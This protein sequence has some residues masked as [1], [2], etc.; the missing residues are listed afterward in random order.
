MEKVH[1]CVKFKRHHFLIY[2]H[3]LSCAHF[4]YV[5]RL[6]H[7]DVFFMIQCRL[8]QWTC[9]FYSLSLLSCMHFLSIL[10]LTLWCTHL[11]KVISIDAQVRP[12]AGQVMVCVWSH[13]FCNSSRFVKDW[14]GL[15]WLCCLLALLLSFCSP[16][17]SSVSALTWLDV[18]S[19][20]RQISI[21]FSDVRFAFLN[22]LLLTW[23]LVMPHTI[24]SYTKESHSRPDV[25]LWLYL[26]SVMYTSVVSGSVS[27]CVK[28]ISQFFKLYGQQ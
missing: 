12:I 8:S 23:S 14:L 18:I 27:V 4:F 16:H 11:C 21:T 5:C 20:G 2:S 28:N 26:K 15:L 3:T 24:L 17:T 10:M 22:S 19:L 13:I 25:Y 6:L 9:L 7:P 1:S